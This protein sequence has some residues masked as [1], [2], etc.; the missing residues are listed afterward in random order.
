LSEVLIHISF[1]NKNPGDDEW[2][3]YFPC[4]YCYIEVDVPFLCDHLHEE[5]CFDMKNAVR[6]NIQQHLQF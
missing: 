3:E 1:V 4:P 5:H 2:W 6:K